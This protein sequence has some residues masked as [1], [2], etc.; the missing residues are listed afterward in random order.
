MKTININQLLNYM[1]KKDD[2]HYLTFN[3]LIQIQHAAF[4]EVFEII[5]PVNDEIILTF[6]TQHDATTF[7]MDHQY[8]RKTLKNVKLSYDLLDAT[9]LILQPVF[10]II[11]LIDSKKEGL[12][13][14]SKNLKIN[15]KLE[16]KQSFSNNEL[17]LYIQNGIIVNPSCII[18]I[19]QD[20]PILSL[21]RIFTMMNNR[22]D[23][24]RLNTIIQLVESE[25][26]YGENRTRY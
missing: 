11:S 3:E 2:I 5:S 18:R 4:D 10:N 21:G 20:F 6:E 16:Y 14:I 26:L 9:K 8:G 12:C 19:N 23:F 24:F 7:Y 25:Q 22:H 1:S 17:S 15:F 13:E